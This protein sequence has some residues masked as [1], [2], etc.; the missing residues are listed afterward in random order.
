MRAISKIT[1]ILAMPL[2]FIF[3]GALILGNRGVCISSLLLFI[4]D[5]IVGPISQHIADRND[6]IYDDFYKQRKEIRLARK[7]MKKNG[8]GYYNDEEM[9]RIIDILVK[10]SRRI[11]Q[12]M[13]GQQRSVPEKC[14]TE[15]IKRHQEHY[16]RLSHLSEGGLFLDNV[17]QDASGKLLID[18]CASLPY[19]PRKYDFYYL[20]GISAFEIEGAPTIWFAVRLINAGA[21]RYA[22]LYLVRVGDRLRL[23]S[24][25]IGGP[26]F[27]CEFIN[28]RHVNYCEVFSFDAREE[29]AEILR[30]EKEREAAAREDD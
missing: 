26:K 12:M 13:Q 19:A 11:E 9:K 29:I 27:L 7:A 2:F 17:D 16:F 30:G 22:S 6:G 24:I 3:I 15:F 14:Q 8:F 1:A 4:I 20:H 25:E 28:G 18:F 10:E 21:I 23:F 5:I